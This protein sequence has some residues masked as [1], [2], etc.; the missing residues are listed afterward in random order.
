MA[1]RQ[2]PFRA[3][4]GKAI[5]HAKHTE[6]ALATFCALCNPD[7]P[8]LLEWAVKLGAGAQI[9]KEELQAMYRECWGE[10]EEE[11]C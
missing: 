2:N 10:L 5:I 3:E 6:N 7:H 11:L 1:W 4:I 9:L 8:D